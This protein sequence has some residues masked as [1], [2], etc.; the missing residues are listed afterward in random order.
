MNEEQI[1]QQINLVRKATLKQMDNLTEGQADKQPDG[2]KN[3]IRWNLG[4]IYV[5]QNS[6]IAKFGGK[7]VE[8]PSR[9]LE[10]FAPGTKPADWQGDVPSLSELKK[11]LEEQPLRLKEALS[12]QLDDEAA[13]AF[14]S[15]PTVGEILTFTLYHEGV[16]TGMIK[17]LKANTAE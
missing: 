5:V 16:H 4:H 3:T 7:P 1:F 6:L 11:E 17:A 9:Y 13:E 10:L 12:G 8:T 15:L 14:L 2:F